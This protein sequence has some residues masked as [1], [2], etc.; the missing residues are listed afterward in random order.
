M[1]SEAGTLDGAL[2]GALPV[3]SLSPL[4]LLPSMPSVPSVPSVPSC[5]FARPFPR[6]DGPAP[7]PRLP[8]AGE[9][10][11]KTPA[12]HSAYPY[13]GL[14]VFVLIHVLSSSCTGV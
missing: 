3:S 13:A 12:Y 1:Y 6:L 10:T 2:D 7:A 11:S 4:P 8:P 9:Y 5:L 14:V